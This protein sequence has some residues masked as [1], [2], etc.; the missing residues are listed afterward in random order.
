MKT[1]IFDK[2]TGPTWPDAK[3]KDV[4]STFLD[5]NETQMTVG[6]SVACDYARLLSAQ[7]RIPIQ[8]SC[9]GEII[10]ITPEGR[11]VTFPN[12]GFADMYDLILNGLLDF[13]PPKC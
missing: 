7:K 12:K 13:P 8:F 2:H 1:I 3:L 10:S 5:S 4:L 11:Y 9:M 6:S